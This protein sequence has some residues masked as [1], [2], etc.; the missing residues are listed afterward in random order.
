MATRECQVCGETANED[1]FV[2]PNC[3][4]RYCRPCAAQLCLN[5]ISSETDFPPR[6]CGRNI[7]IQFVWY[8]L[9]PDQMVLYNAKAAEYT[10]PNR[11]YCHVQTCST[12]IAPAAYDRNTATCE[13]CGS[14][15]CTMCRGPSHLDDCPPEDE[16]MQQLLAHAKERR[17]QRCPR[18]KNLIERISGCR[19]MRCTC[20]A[21]YCY[22]CG[23]HWVDCT[24]TGDEDEDDDDD[25]DDDDEEDDEDDENDEDDE[26]DESMDNGAGAHGGE[27]NQLN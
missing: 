9:E 27:G 2:T 14:K 1:G 19:R 16:S 13:K 18:C 24:C 15:T 3:H 11:I 5:A 4:H 10:A 21:Y 20:G 25:D 6:C 22:I 12:F 26:G 23:N 7:P 8:V 17:W